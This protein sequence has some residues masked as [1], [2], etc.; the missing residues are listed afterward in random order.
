M[1]R[2]EHNCHIRNGDEDERD[3]LHS[4][5][6]AKKSNDRDRDIE[7]LFDR[8]APER[9]DGIRGNPS[10]PTDPP[11]AGKQGEGSPRARIFRASPGNKLRE[12]DQTIEDQK[13]QRPDAQDAPHI[14]GLE[15]DR[16][17]L[18]AFPEEQF[19]DEK[20][21]QQ[22]EDRYAQVPKKTDVVEPIMLRRI[23]RNKVHPMDDKHDHEGDEAEHVKF[24]G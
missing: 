24:G 8:N 9:I 20:C 16:P 22:E 17:S 4:N 18:V 23:D 19:R 5:A 12:H 1:H 13:V 6:A 2:I 14:K 3:R 11:V 21:A 15:L 7:L 10:V